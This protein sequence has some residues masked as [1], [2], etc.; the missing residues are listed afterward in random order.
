[1]IY[2]YTCITHPHTHTPSTHTSLPPPT[3]KHTHTHILSQ[4]V[5]LDIDVQA[6]LQSGEDGHSVQDILLQVSLLSLVQLLCFVVLQ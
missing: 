2:Y 6:C 5:E 4:P 1:M 3:N